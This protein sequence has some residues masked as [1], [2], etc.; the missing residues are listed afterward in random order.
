MSNYSLI[1]ALEGKYWKHSLFRPQYNKN[2]KNTKNAGRK[3]KY[4]WLLS[5]CRGEI[6]YVLGW[7]SSGE[8]LV[9]QIIFLPK[10]SYFYPKS[11]YKQCFLEAKTVKM[12]SVGLS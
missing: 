7:D 9:F 6:L 3:A 8:L 2:C 1:I 10:N 11:N 12:E 5:F 4:R